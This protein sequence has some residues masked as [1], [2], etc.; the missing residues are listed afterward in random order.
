MA[1]T[2]MSMS[3][4][5]TKKLNQMVKILEMLDGGATREEVLK[6][7][8]LTDRRLNYVLRNRETLLKKSK[9]LVEFDQETG[10]FGKFEPLNL[11]ILK[12]MQ[13]VYDK[14]IVPLTNY[15]SLIQG[16]ATELAVSMGCDS[17]SANSK[18]LFYIRK[19]FWHYQTSQGGGFKRKGVPV[20]LGEV[21]EGFGSTARRPMEKVTPIVHRSSG[22]FQIFLNVINEFQKLS[23]KK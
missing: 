13:E 11:A 9:E 8:K 23:R 6:K 1:V 10:K 20:Q 14:G 19:R 3:T 21:S 7:F 5:K 18:W 17:F 12:W 15:Y 2:E 4:Y 22:M 16:K